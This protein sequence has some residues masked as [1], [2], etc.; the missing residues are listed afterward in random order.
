[1]KKLT[2]KTAAKSTSKTFTAVAS[3]DVIDSTAHGFADGDAVEVE[4][5]GGTIPAGLS[6]NTVYFVRDQTANTFKLDADLAKLAAVVK[7]P[8]PVDMAKVQP[9][10]KKG[11][12]R[13][14][15]VRLAQIGKV[16]EEKTN[17][18][19]KQFITKAEAAER[20]ANDP[21]FVADMI[22]RLQKR[23]ET[24]TDQRSHGFMLSHKTAGSKLAE[25]VRSGKK[26]DG[27]Q[28]KEA[29]RISEYYV[30]QI[31]GVLR[32]EAVRKDKT[33]ELK[34]LAKVYGLVIDSGD[35]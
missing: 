25:I 9:M 17:A 22:V 6:E 19:P 31:C 4:S 1:M 2:K 32:S 34:K 35:A 20:I 18:W 21:A 23:T 3:T 16:L 14:M 27:A 11:D 28:L 5:E 13:P 7:G 29:R 24:R 33:G 30:K 26:L 8:A 10:S 12:K 15:N